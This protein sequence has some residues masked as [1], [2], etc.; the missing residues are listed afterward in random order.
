MDYFYHVFIN[1]S[2]HQSFGAMDIVM[3]EQKSL[4]LH[5]KYIFFCFKDGQKSCGFWTT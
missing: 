1:F 5:L 2:K 4:R 3:E